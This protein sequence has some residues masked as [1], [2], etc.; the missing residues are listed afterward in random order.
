MG[1][2]PKKNV[3]RSRPRKKLTN[4]CRDTTAA[5]AK[6]EKASIAVEAISTR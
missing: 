4:P 6:G 1:L 3:Q 5:L 2:F